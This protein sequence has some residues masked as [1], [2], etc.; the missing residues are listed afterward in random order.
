MKDRIF[1]TLVIIC[2]ILTT[3]YFTYQIAEKQTL[4]SARKSFERA[5]I[6][7]EVGGYDKFLDFQ[8]KSIENIAVKYIL[9]KQE[10]IQ[11]ESEH[12]EHSGEKPEKEK[13]KL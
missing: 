12:P 4:E 2:F 3:N 5:A 6:S 1:L 13:F 7:A 9:E 8:F 11:S 10:E